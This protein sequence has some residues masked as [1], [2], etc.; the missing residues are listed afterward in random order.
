MLQF[1]LDNAASVPEAIKLLESIQVVMG[2]ALGH[3]ASLHLAIED[4]TGDSAI[5][6]WVNGKMII[7]HGRQYWVMTND[8]PFDQQLALLAGKDFSNP[9]SDTLLPGNVKATDR[10][11]RSAYF[12]AMLPKPKSEREA[13]SGV[14][15]IARNA[16]VPFGAPYAGFGIYNTKYRT[17]MNLNDRRY[18]FE[19]ANAPNVVW[20][21]LSKF[22]LKPNAPVMMLD[23][24]NVH[25]S[26]D[27][28]K[29][30]EKQSKA[31]F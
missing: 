10:F 9:S 13:I 12:L 7:H 31:L 6:E 11:Q 8:P 2:E 27:V 18:Y 3:K 25:L 26:G 29:S 19:L 5:A 22:D 20:A 28:S 21:D 24:D 1:V 4:A 17:A 23:P 14:M 15:A 16:S 30:F